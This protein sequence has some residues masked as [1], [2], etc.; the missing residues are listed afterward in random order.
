MSDSASH[1]NEENA[2]NNDLTSYQGIV[3]NK[4]DC[5]YTS[6]YCEE[7]IW[8]LCRHIALQKPCPIEEVYVIFISNE[9]RMIPLWKQKSSRGGNPVIWDYHVILLHTSHSGCHIYDL[10]TILPFPCSLKCYVDEAFR[11]DDLINLTFKR[12]LRVI[13]ADTFLK[14]FASDR[15]H[16]KDPTGEWRMP[17]PPYPCIETTECKMNLDD[18]ISM[19]A[20]IG[21]GVVYTLTDFTQQFSEK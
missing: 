2:M 11:S 18:F 6:C 10:D 5:I 8:K 19:D 13:P 14:T 4:K 1:T 15:S 16:M 9:S 20:N 7:N 12:K 3:P 21:W 17:P